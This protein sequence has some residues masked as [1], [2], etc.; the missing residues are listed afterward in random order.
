MARLRPL[1]APLSTRLSKQTNDLLNNCNYRHC[2]ETRFSENE[3]LQS[4]KEVLGQT[5]GKP[6]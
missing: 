5:H 6:T 2:A 1:S 3:T 4:Y